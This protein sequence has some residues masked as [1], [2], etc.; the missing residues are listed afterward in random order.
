MKLEVFD[1][2]IND[3]TGGSSVRKAI[4]DHGAHPMEFY[5]AIDA[6]VSWCERYT[7]AKEASMEAMADEILALADNP[8]AALKTTTKADGSVETVEGDAVERTRIQI[9]SRKWLLSKLA[10]KRYGE[11]LDLTANVNVGDALIER[12]ANGRQRADG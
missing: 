4:A 12:L 7:R 6:N 1:A 8:V 3:V 2:I 5:R 10:P 11:K 9:D